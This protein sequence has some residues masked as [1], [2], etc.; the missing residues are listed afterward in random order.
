MV[1]SLADRMWNRVCLYNE[2]MGYMQKLPSPKV[3]WRSDRSDTVGLQWLHDY[4]RPEWGYVSMWI[5][6]EGI[7]EYFE[8]CIMTLQTEIKRYELMQQGVN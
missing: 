2:I 3:S 6:L 8:Q 1:T 4:R 7:P 5:P